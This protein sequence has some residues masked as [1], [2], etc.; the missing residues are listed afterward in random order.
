MNQ[1]HFWTALGAFGL[2]AAVMYIF[3]PQ[4]GRRRRAQARDQIAS[5][6]RQITDKATATYNDL[7]SRLYAHLQRLSLSFHARAAVGDLIY[8]VTADTYA[9]QTLAMN[10][11]FPILSAALLLGGMLV[12]MVRLDPLM[13][14]VACAVIPVLAVGIVFVNR[15]ISAAAVEMRERE[16]E[17]Y[18]IVQRNLSA[19]INIHD[20]ML[21]QMFAER[22]VGLRQ[23]EIVYDGPPDKLTPAVLTSIY[24]EEDWSATIRKVDEEAPD[25]ELD[26]VVPFEVPRPDRD[27]MAGL[28]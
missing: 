3:D 6:Q 16:S 5:A 11:L 22:I 9:I 12:V 18:Q 19:I 2:G 1:S 14:A 13:T 8:R 25:A 26:N 21:A 24:G 28:T 27:R 20:V 23:G 15:R 17:V 7:R 10:G 4:Q